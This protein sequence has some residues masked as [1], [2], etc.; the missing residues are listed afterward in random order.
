[1][2]PDGEKRK[3]VVVERLFIQT[4]KTKLILH[5]YSAVLPL[6]KKYVLL[7][8]LKEP[9]IHR[10]NDK[11]VELVQEFFVCFIKAEHLNNV[12]DKKLVDLD[13]SDKKLCLP[14]KDMFMGDKA[15]KLVLAETRRSDPVQQF[16]NCLQR[17]Y[18]K[19]RNICDRFIFANFVSS[20]NS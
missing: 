6:L 3:H 7:F 19:T 11:Q 8:E 20:K 5:T 10:L 16:L 12:S 17:A 18:C 1:M 14:L 2:T 13:V 9:Q 4:L 15:L